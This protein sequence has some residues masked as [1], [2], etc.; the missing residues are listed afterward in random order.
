MINMTY[1]IVIRYDCL[2]W[3]LVRKSAVTFEMSRTRDSCHTSLPTKCR[4][5]GVPPRHQ[6]KNQKTTEYVQYANQ[7]IFT[8]DTTFVS[9]NDEQ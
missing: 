4:K 7:G 3:P 6:S 5:F 9:T 2:L 8:K 1:Y